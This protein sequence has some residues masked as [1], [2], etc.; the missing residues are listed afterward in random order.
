MDNTKVLIDTSIIIDHFRKSDKTNT[1]LVQHFK[2]YS[3]FI[4]SITVFELYNGA[5][6]PEKAHDIELILK[7]VEVIDVNKKIAIEASKIYLLLAK[8]NKAIE[9]RD[10]LIAATAIVS[11]MPIDTLNV[12][13]FS[14]IAG[15]KLI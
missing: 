6:S 3:L 7:N 10:I 15:L 9:F 8:K 13:H 4:S 12:N 2:K 1:R 14:R 5:S 11:K